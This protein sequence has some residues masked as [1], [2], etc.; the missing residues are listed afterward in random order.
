MEPKSSFLTSILVEFDERLLAYTVRNAIPESNFLLTF[1][2]SK[3][4]SAEVGPDHVTTFFRIGWSG[5]SFSSLGIIL[6][7]QR[8]SS[9][10]MSRMCHQV[11]V[12]SLILFDPQT[13]VML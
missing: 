7:L 3:K 2:F 9:I 5:G 12:T 6:W 13:P 8:E 4:I 11:M 1:T 10:L